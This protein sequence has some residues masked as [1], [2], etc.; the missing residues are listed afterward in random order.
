MLPYV[1]SVTDHR[2]RQNEVRTSVTHSSN[3]PFLFLPHF[4]VLCDQ[5]LNRR[6]QHGIYLLN[7]CTHEDLFYVL[8]IGNR[9]QQASWLLLMN[10]VL[11]LV[12][13]N[14]A[15]LQEQK[16]RGELRKQ[17][18]AASNL[19]SVSNLIANWE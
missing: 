8:N 12:S 13:V 16:I 15:S 14:E 9:L 5:L 3:V 6:S 19:A 2:R 1:C 18:I 4:D 11:N 10:Y 17:N 7:G